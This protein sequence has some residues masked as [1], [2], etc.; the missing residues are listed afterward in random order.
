MKSFLTLGLGLGLAASA[1]FAPAHAAPSPG[2]E[3]AAF[4]DV[5]RAISAHAAPDEAIE[6]CQKA[7][8]A[9]AALGSW[10]PAVKTFAGWNL[11]RV[12]RKADAARI[13]ESALL[14]STAGAKVTPLARAADR[15]A[16]RWLTRLDSESV[17][18]ALRSYYAQQIAYPEALE[19]VFAAGA[20]LPTKDRFG[21]AWNYS[22]ADSTAVAGL[23]GQ[24]FSLTSKSIGRTTPLKKALK[25]SAEYSPLLVKPDLKRSVIEF[26]AD[27][28]GPKGIAQEGG[29][30]VNGFR[31]VKIS[32]GGRFALMTDED[33][34]LWAIAK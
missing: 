7:L 29:R 25:L 34:D 19:A 21:D 26:R 3:D 5:A 17:R 20:D 23:Q 30:S 18:T 2:A 22:R 15:M 8:N 16:R 27:E 9:P 33:G 24:F 31:L 28:K 13:F 1:F 14:K 10:L 4:A 32:S 12:G 11:L 6:I